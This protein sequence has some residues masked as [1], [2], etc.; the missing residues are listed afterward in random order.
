MVSVFLSALDL[1][2][3]ATPLPAIASVLSDTKGDYIWIR[4]SF[5]AP[6]ITYPSCVK[7]VGSAYA[8]SSTVFIPL[9]GNLADVFGRYTFRSS[10]FLTLR[11]S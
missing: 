6:Y 5:L 3:I 7:Q 4:I 10:A 1:T 2:T 9:S 11:F 8:L